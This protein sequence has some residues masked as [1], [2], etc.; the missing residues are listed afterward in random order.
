MYQEI[1][2]EIATLPIVSPHGHTDPSWFANNT[3]FPDPA[4]LLITPDHYVFRLLYSR[5]VPLLDLGVGLPEQARDPRSIFRVVAENWFIFLGTPVD[6]WMM[7]TFR[8]VFEID[9]PLLPETADEIFDQ[10]SA[11]LQQPSFRPLELAAQF[12]IELIATTDGCNDLLNHH[13]SFG[14]QD[15]RPLTLIPTFRPDNV[16]NPLHPVFQTALDELANASGGEVDTY[17]GYLHA[18]QVRRAYFKDRGA[19]A[20]DHDVPD[21]STEW[22]TRNEASALFDRVRSGSASAQEAKRFYAHMLVEMAQMSVEDGLVMQIHGGSRRSTNRA[23]FEEHGSDIG[24]DIPA[25][26]NWVDGLNALLNRVGNDPKMRLIA[27]TLDESCLSRELAPMAGHW[28]ALML[29]PPWWFHDSENGIERYFDRVVESAGYWNLA[30]FNDDTRAFLS[31]PA[32]HAMWR[33]GVAKHLTRQIE[34]G[35]LTDEAA[36]RVAKR[37][38]RDAAIESYRLELN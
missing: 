18:L 30:G 37:L 3:P 36:I 38:A 10:V 22:L 12:K 25:P 16:L 9:A 8:D 5:G 6:R 23:L 1:L 31:I 35:R 20:T 4:S 26:A 19:A 21:V 34:D 28:P 17:D 32:R 11:K 27:F 29:G 7:D 13:E 15:V 2:D 14:R 33:R 24:A